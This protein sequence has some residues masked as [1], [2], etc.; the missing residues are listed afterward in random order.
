MLGR[1]IADGAELRALEPWRAAEFAAHVD[2]ARHHLAPWLPW[3]TRIVDEESARAFLQSYADR[4]ARDTGRIVGIWLHDTLVGGLLFRVFDSQTGTCE[5][6][7]WLEP[8]AQG[9]GLITRAAQLAVD[10]AINARGMVR[11]EW[12]TVPA[13]TRSIAAAKR[14]GMRLDG[15]LRQA[16][17]HQG[18]HHDVQV[19]SRLA[20]DPVDGRT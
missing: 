1:P 7:V 17:P 6:G 5:I 2:R 16:F 3:A 8:D 10:W 18:R 19:W 20:T 12:R 15:V 13:N 4:Q 9:R 14:L 11:V